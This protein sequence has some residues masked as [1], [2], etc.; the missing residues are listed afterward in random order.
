M[1]EKFTIKY[2]KSDLKQFLLIFVPIIALSILA[3]IASHYT[4]ITII[5]LLFMAVIAVFYII[6]TKQFYVTVS[7]NTFSYRNRFGKSDS[8]STGD[9]SDIF[10]E[11]NIILNSGTRISLTITA[12]EKIL[13]F[14]P[15][16]ENFDMLAGY[17]LEKIESGEINKSVLTHNDIEELKKFKDKVYKTKD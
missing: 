5:S 9:I 14:N 13:V 2:P 16:M 15:E 6:S 10:C 12:G 7:D 4:L 17:L 1:N 11:C 8:F 3:V